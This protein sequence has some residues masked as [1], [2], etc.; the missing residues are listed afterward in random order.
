MQ[1]VVTPGG[2]TGETPHPDGPAVSLSDFVA[3]SQQNQHALAWL[4]VALRQAPAELHD[5]LGELLALERRQEALVQRVMAT[6]FGIRLASC[7][8]K[9]DEAPLATE[10]AI[11]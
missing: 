7:C 2:R 1:D 10:E 3:F 5:V 9:D 6:R 11:P 8:P 4:S